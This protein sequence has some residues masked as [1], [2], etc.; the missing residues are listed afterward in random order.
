MGKKTPYI[1]EKVS[2]DDFAAEGV[3]VAKPEGKVIFV[4]NAVPGD[5]ADLRIFRDKRSY[6][7]A[8]AIHIHHYS[9]KRQQP[10]CEHFGECGGC[11]WQHV[12]YEEQL[13]F[14]YQQVVEQF[15][16]VGKF[17]FPT[18]LPILKSKNTIHYRNKLE[19]SFSNKRWITRQESL[20]ENTLHQEPALGF[21]ISGRFDKILDIHTCYLQDDLSNHIRN[22]IRTY[23]L[24]N[25][26]TFFDIQQQEG[27]LR[28]MILRNNRNGEW[29]LIMIFGYND[30]HEINKLMEALKAQFPSIVSLQY[31]IN[32]KKNDS[33]HDLP[34]R[35]YHGS[36][37]L[38]EKLD[39]L[40]F[41]IQPKSFFQT[42]TLQAEIL[43]RK[44][45]EMAALTGKENVYDLYT[46]TGTIACFL[47]NHAKQ[48]IGI[49][50]VTDAIEDA[51]ENA[52]LNQLENLHFYAGD[53]KDLLQPELF[54]KHG[55]PD[56]IITDPPRAGMHSDVVKMLNFSG[57]NRIVYVSCNPATQARDI[58]LMKDYYRI[59]QV[60]PIDMFPHTHHV[61]N[62]VLLVKK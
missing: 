40:T 3:S 4:K 44:T 28:N 55:Y 42:N 51:K 10:F 12:K 14:K 39:D 62:I 15:K 19:F 26:L 17:E 2:I 52:Q 49:E 53:M 9:D 6:A 43:Y 11:K 61:E 50:Y 38:I 46:G 45:R 32:T 54:K 34:V 59:E 13:N 5:V 31:V 18:P 20:S 24:K 33:I 37:I 36:S 30:L 56:V 7:E 25:R 48:V 35:L 16:R 47:A 58:S 21:H 29:M 23:A 27:F 57:A 8:E 22:F 60:Q 1:I 41:R